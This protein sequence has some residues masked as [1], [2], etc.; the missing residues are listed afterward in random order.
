MRKPD[1]FKDQVADLMDKHDGFSLILKHY[2]VTSENAAEKMIETFLEGVQYDKE[3][4]QKLKNL[5]EY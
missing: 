4:T 5:G 3:L 1:N 2:N